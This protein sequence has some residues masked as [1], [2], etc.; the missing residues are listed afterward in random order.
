MHRNTVHRAVKAYEINTKEWW[1]HQRIHCKDCGAEIDP[2][3]KLGERAR[4]RLIGREEP[5][6]DTCKAE[7]RKVYNRE[8][9]REWRARNRSKYNAYMK[10]GAKRPR[11][12]A[13]HKGQVLQE[14]YVPGVWYTI[15]SYI[16]V[17]RREPMTLF[18]MCPICGVKFT[19]Q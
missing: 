2:E 4:K 18:A 19:R 1:K 5:L 15:P 6:C 14:D 13:S 12:V 16:V 8:K 3:V 11:R 10:N 17:R 7:R 9:Q